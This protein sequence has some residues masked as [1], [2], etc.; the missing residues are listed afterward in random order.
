M[1]VKARRKQTTVTTNPTNQDDQG[2]LR[3]T[4]REITTYEKQ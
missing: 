2:L 3:C 1:K 4:N